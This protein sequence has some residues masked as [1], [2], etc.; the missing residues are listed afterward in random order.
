MTDRLTLGDEVPPG[1]VERVILAPRDR[2]AVRVARGVL[3]EERRACR[4]ELGERAHVRRPR[5]RV[6]HLE[7]LFRTRISAAS[8]PQMRE[9]RTSE[10]TSYT[11]K[12]ELRLVSGV[13]D[14][15]IHACASA[16][17]AFWTVALLA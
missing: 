5:V 11:R 1:T 16:V 7:R 14:G 17:E 10:S 8:P 12:P 6:E 4:A 2:R 13:T 9:G 3:V 15:Q